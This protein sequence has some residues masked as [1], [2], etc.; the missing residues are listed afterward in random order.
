VNLED[1]IAPGPS[2][3]ACTCCLGAAMM[4]AIGGC[5]LSNNPNPPGSER[6]NTFFTGTAASSPKYLDPTSA[7]A[8]NELPF[9][10]AIYEPL[11]RYHYLKRPYQLA[12]RAAEAVPEPRYLDASGHVLA[13]DAP[14]ETVAE[15]VYDI[16]IRRGILYAPHPAFAKGADGR[17]VY[18]RLE[19]ESVAAKFAL[20]DF[21]KAGTRELVAEDFVYAI[22]RIASPRVVS[23]S[24]SVME[25]HLV[26]MKDFSQRVRAVD[27]GLRAGLAATVRDL[28]FL[29]LRDI[30]FDGAS[31]I[32]D[33][34]LRI[35]V[36]GKYPQ[37]KHWMA[38]TFFAPI[39][40]EAEA[41]YA[42]PGMSEHNLSL[43]Y[44][45]AGTGPYM[46]T[47]YVENR[48]HTLVRNPNFR[49]EPYPCD[50]EPGDR[51]AGLLVDCGMTM[52]FID[53]IVI[54]V[55][56]E[57]LTIKSKWRQGYLDE[58]T[59]ETFGW[60]LEFSSEARSSEAASAEFREKGFRF[61]RS[62]DAIDLYVG[63]NWLDPVVGGGASAM[64][65]ERNRKLR[66]ALQIAVD[67]E[68]YTQIFESL[69]QAGPTATS[70]VPPQLFGFRPG[71]EGM[72]DVAFAWRD[73]GAGGGRAVR[74]PIEA[75]KRLMEE[76]GYPGGR[77]VRTGRPLTLNYDFY[78]L[79]TPETQAHIDWLTKQFGK[80]G[81]QLELRA[82][83][84]NRFQDKLAHGSVQVF[85]WGW[86]ADYPDTETFLA[87]LHGPNAKATTGG[88][89]EN[90]S[91]YRNDEYDRLFERMRFLDDGPQKQD[92]IDRMVAIARRDSPWLWGY[93]PYSMGA[94][95]PWMM[96]GKPTSMVHDV[97][98]Y[99]RLDPAMRAT[100]VKQWNPT[101]VWPLWF[102]AACLAFVIWNAWR[103]FRLREQTNA[104]GARV[105]GA[106]GQR[107]AGS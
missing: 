92:L 14:G 8:S 19:R 84:L 33:H 70:P 57:R 18:G 48:Q 35:R 99:R 24:F 3:Q 58:P 7:Y 47:E 50:G 71:R 40:W 60:G 27:A 49:G 73:E 28:P 61:P 12:G 26:G 88:H 97:F 59:M 56:K 106:P 16:R 46:A 62:V 87:L 29:D 15:T 98:Q 10:Y 41:F 107:L 100:L 32:D 5:G 11:L 93:N 75:A 63:F 104:L 103:A 69:G 101:H 64:D 82:S 76:A 38:M 91:N 95:Q 20:T 1:T 6:T 23:P 54:R 39:P 25:E 55:E 51:E 78:R 102:I 21:E 43:N 45:P 72:D 94:Y 2:L 65:A 22:K 96:N 13:A 53:R 34:T 37:F 42:Q 89:G 30:P 31:A 83:D 77:D 9:T 80:L 67:W 66:Q 52:P 85:S 17:L 74:R 68:E 79:P 4:V 36:I 81:V 44:W 90:A 86:N 105:I